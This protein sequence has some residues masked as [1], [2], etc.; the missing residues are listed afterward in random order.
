MCRDWEVHTGTSAAKESTTERKGL[1]GGYSRKARAH[2]VI[3]PLRT[4]IVNFCLSKKG[5]ERE[6][7]Y[8]QV[9]SPGRMVGL[10]EKYAVI[11][12]DEIIVGSINRPSDRRHSLQMTE[13]KRPDHRN[14]CTYAWLRRSRILRDWPS[15]IKTCRGLTGKIFPS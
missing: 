15:S 5:Q 6:D 9:C 2:I 4:R 7:V 1:S 3:S 11:N 14:E 13:N 8:S 10:M 12:K